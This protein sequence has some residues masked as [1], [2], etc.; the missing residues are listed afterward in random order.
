VLLLKP[1]TLTALLLCF[2]SSHIVILD[3]IALT[4]LDG[5]QEEHPACKNGVCIWPSY[6]TATP[7]SL[8]LLK[9]S[10]VS[11]FWCRLT[12]VVLKKRPLNITHC[13]YYYSYYITVV[14]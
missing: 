11:L 13:Y 1:D 9:S 5:H 10:L 4:L 14:V 2:Q 3:F 8:A 6:V 7:S 12:Q